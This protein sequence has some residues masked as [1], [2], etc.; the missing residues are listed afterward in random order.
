M[1]VSPI[2]WVLKAES[3]KVRIV[4]V[5]CAINA[6]FKPD[7]GKCVLQTLT[8][9]RYVCEPFDWMLTT[10]KH[11]SFFHY[12]LCGRDRAWTGFSL[13]PDELHNGVADLIVENTVPIA[14]I[15]HPVA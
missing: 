3:S 9:Q 6:M 11:N 2:K 4:I 12:E 5:L 13:H 8:S 15:Q 1:G 7:S 14:F 10:D